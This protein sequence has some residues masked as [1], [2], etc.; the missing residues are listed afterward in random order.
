MKQ[1]TFAPFAQPLYV[2]LKPVGAICNLRC[3]YCYYL[4]KKELYPEDK[5]YTMSDRLLEKFIEEYIN[6]LIVA[7]KLTDSGNFELR[8]L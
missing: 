8:K 7:L 6:S 1:S 5:N 4:E 3:N 2:M